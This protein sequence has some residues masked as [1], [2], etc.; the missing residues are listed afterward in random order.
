MAA[1]IE[2]FVYLIGIAFFGF[3]YATLK[4]AVGA[5]AWFLVGVIGYLCFLRVVGY[6]ARRC[7]EARN[8]R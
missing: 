7:M 1:R 5:D 4:N 8:R 2:F 6:V 3:F